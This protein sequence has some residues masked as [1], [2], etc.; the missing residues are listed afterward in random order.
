MSKQ[1]SAGFIARWVA[2]YVL[3][4]QVV[5]TYVLEL[6]VLQTNTHWKHG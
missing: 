6:C 5:D 1:V 2:A 3:E 4:A